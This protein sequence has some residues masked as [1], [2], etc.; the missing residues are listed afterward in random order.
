MLYPSL[1]YLVVQTD[2]FVLI[3]EHDAHRRHRGAGWCIGCGETSQWNMVIHQILP[4]YFNV[5]TLC[6][7]EIP[8]D[9]FL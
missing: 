6:A 9:E 1:I 7:D 2:D 4:F 8:T 5:E 3:I